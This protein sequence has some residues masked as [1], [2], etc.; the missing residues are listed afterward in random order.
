MK[1]IAILIGVTFAVLGCGGGGD[2]APSTAGPPAPTV[3]LSLSQPKLSVGSSALITWKSTGATSCTAA[4]GWV[5]TKPTSGSEQITPLASGHAIY[6]ITCSGTGGTGSAEVAMTVP[7]PVKRSSYENKMMAGEALGPVPVP[8]T[9]IPTTRTESERISAGVAMADF[10]QEGSLSAVVFSGRED[11]NSMSGT[12]P[13]WAV[14]NVYF[15]KY[16]NGQWINNTSKIL[17]DATGCI[18]PRKVLVADFNGDGKPDVFASCTGHDDNVDG[19]LPGEHPRLLLSQPDGSYTN[20][21]F[22]LNCYCHSATAIDLTG[23]GYADVIVHDNS[24]G[25]LMYFVNNKDGTYTRD[26]SRL[27]TSALP[28]GGLGEYSHG[29]WTVEALEITKPGK[30]DLFLGG[31]DLINC[32]CGWSWSSKIYKNDGSNKWSDASVIELPSLPGKVDVWDVIYRDGSVYILRVD[33]GITQ[34]WPASTNPWLDDSMAIERVNIK[35]L[36]STVVYEHTG[37]FSNG[38]TSTNEWIIYHDGKIKN[39][40]TY[41]EIAVGL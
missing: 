14:G 18:S 13:T 2:G 32:N 31:V 29:I 27:P 12:G 4:G 7:F 16:V 15:F 36:Q 33:P 11:A 40:Y 1:N 22:P 39:F 6:T 20:V 30:Y 26:Q 35:T 34:S 9:Q 38:Y 37:P 41:P 3:T 28:F 24:G 17:K 8:P 5:G 10:F 21:A 23:T 25:G 19:K